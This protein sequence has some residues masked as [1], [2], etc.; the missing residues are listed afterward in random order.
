[1]NK[2]KKNSLKSPYHIPFIA[3]NAFA[4]R[5]LAKIYVCQTCT[6]HIPDHIPFRAN[7]DKVHIEVHDRY[8]LGIC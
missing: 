8:M 6:Y 5:L 4:E 7:M 1:M 3:G 2:C